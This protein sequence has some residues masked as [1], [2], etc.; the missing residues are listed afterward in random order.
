[1]VRF[2]KVPLVLGLAL[3]L[4]LVGALTK[5]EAPACGVGEPGKFSRLNFPKDFIWGTATAAFQVVIIYII[6]FF[7]YNLLYGS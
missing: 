2:E 6:C 5:A 4:T 1:M 7:G 3:V